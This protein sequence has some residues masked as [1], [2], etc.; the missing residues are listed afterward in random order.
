M[1]LDADPVLYKRMLSAPLLK[2][3][4]FETVPALDA[5]AW[6][7]GIRSIMETRGWPALPERAPDRVV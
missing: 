1:A 4:E 3:N 7:A 5:K 6:G 2:G